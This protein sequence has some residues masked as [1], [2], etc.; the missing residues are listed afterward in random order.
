M[1]RA[2]M[3]RGRGDTVTRRRA[4]ASQLH[5]P[6][7]RVPPSPRQSLN[8]GKGAAASSFLV[9]Q[10]E[11][12]AYRFHP[13]QLLGGVGLCL[14]TAQRLVEDPRHQG[15][16]EGTQAFAIVGRL[17]RELPL[18]FLFQVLAPPGD[19]RNDGEVAVPE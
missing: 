15:I 10:V 6:R 13:L 4:E 14:E 11:Q 16:A 19:R 9:V 1:R 17:A 12:V 7:L 8:C 3:T 2:V 18:H 5:S